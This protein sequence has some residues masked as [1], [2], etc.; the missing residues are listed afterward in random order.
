MQ[1]TSVVIVDDHPVVRQGLNSL[2]SQFPDIQV[3]GE[4]GTITTALVLIDKL[5]PDIVLLDIRLTNQNGLH[6][7]RKIHRNEAKS[8]VI[9]LTS[10]EDEA[11]LQE[12]AEAG[13]YGYLLKSASSEVL[14]DAI[15][16]VHA[17]ERRISETMVNAALEQLVILSQA[18]AREESGLSEQELQLLQLLADGVSMEEIS[19]TLY[20]SE[21]TVKRKLK[22][23][24]NKLEAA[25]RVQAVAE[26]YKRGLL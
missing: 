25:N 11:Y 4:A 26:A 13:V 8:R 23:I 7:A 17:G 3:V 15:R 5:E 24:L 20:L 9:V 14:A 19:K 1:N 6:I 18:R 10:H 16:A 2:L 22:D 21:R 12:A